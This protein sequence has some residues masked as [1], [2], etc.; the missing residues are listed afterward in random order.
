M[1][2]TN[3]IFKYLDF[4]SKSGHPSYKFYDDWNTYEKRC[5]GEDPVGAKLV[6]PEPEQDIVDLEAYI[7]QIRDTEV[8]EN[9]KD[10]SLQVEE[11]KEKEKDEEEYRE[12]DPIRK[13]QFDYNKT[14][15]MTNKYPEANFESALSF[16]P[17]VWGN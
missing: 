14:T 2:D 4:L 3:K 16:A 6:F 7:N 17:A 1:I 12:K 5:L 11:E 9:N 10:G 8:D 13:Y 15:C